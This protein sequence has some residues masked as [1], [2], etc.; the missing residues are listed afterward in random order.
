M[1]ENIWGT[2]YEG[3][4]IAVVYRTAFFTPTRTA[5]LE[6]DGEL[7]QQVRSGFAPFTRTILHKHDFSGTEKEVEVRIAPKGHGFTIG[8]QILVNGAF[9]AGDDTIRYRDPDEA[10]KVL[11]KG[12]LSFLLRMGLIQYS[13]LF[14]VVWTAGWATLM[15]IRYRAEFLNP[16]ALWAFV[17]LPFLCYLFAVFVLGL[18]VAVLEWRSITTQRKARNNF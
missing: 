6:I 9:V 15:A 7:V 18:I 13:P 5:S 16:R 8:C 11:E 1:R 2:R 4:L 17:G 14:A 10:Q 3:H 12:F